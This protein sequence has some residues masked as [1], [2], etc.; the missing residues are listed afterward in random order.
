M[1]NWNIQPGRRYTITFKHWKTGEVLQIHGEVPTTL[2]NS[3]SD[4]LVVMKSRG[5][6]EDI[7]KSTIVDVKGCKYENT[8]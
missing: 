6:Y 4:R 1:S 3:K 7:I 8:P 5:C 2:N